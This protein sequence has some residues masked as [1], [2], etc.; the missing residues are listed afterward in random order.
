MRFLAEKGV[1]KRC[2]L[3]TGSFF[4]SIPAGHDIYLMKHIL[5]NWSDEQ[6]TELLR[7]CRKA[8]TPHGKLL[9]LEMLPAGNDFHP[10]K[11]FDISMMVSLGGKE[12]TEL[13]FS[14]LLAQSDFKLQRILPMESPVVILEANPG[15]AFSY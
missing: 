11:W 15:I 13:E 6:A 7:C 14:R 4:E 5:H 8:I 1:S 2:D 10:A 12:R 9:I 3:V